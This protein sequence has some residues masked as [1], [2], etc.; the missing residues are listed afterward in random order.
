[1]RSVLTLKLQEINKQAAT[2]QD[3]QQAKKV[4]NDSC[5]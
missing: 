2:L 4:L 5:N 3:N 1:M